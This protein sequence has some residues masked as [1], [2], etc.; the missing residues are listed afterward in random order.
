ME[1]S[2]M[3]VSC[4][5]YMVL[6]VLTPNKQFKLVDRAEQRH[7]ILTVNRIISSLFHFV[8]HMNPI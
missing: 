5:V 3:C 4:L 7:Q 2:E 1:D 6:S 8:V